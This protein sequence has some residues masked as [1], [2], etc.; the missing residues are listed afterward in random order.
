MI[1]GQSLIFSRQVSD[2]FLSLRVLRQNTHQPSTS[3]LEFHKP[4]TQNGQPPHHIHR[5]ALP[6]TS[7]N[8]TNKSSRCRPHSHNWRDRPLVS[9]LTHLHAPGLDSPNPHTLGPP[10]LSNRHPLL[11]APTLLGGPFHILSLSTN[12]RSLPGAPRRTP[13]VCTARDTEPGERGSVEE[14][15]GEGRGWV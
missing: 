6:L 10:L 4:Q 9:P 1:H 11:H 13:S 8:P 12:D 3:N 14:I 5:Q 7:R 15:G 2:K